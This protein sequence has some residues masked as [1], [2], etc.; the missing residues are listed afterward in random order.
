MV[1]CPDCNEELSQFSLSNKNRKNGLKID[2]L[3]EIYENSNEHPELRSACSLCEHFYPG[4]GDI[5]IGLY[6]LKTKSEF[7]IYVQTPLGQQ[8]I[9]SLNLKMDTKSIKQQKIREEVMTNLK[10]IRTKKA[11]E[12]VKATEKSIKG[13]D[14]FMNVLSPCINCHNCMTVC[15]ICYCKTCLFKSP[16]FDHEP[17]QYL[18]WARRK[19][20]YRLP[21]DTMLF[22]LTRLNHMVLS[23]VGCGMCTS[24]CPADLPVGRVFRTIAQQVQAAFDYTPGRSVDDPLPLITFRE[25]EWTEIGEE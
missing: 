3:Y 25:D 7:L 15:P 13:I 16:T 23:C 1:K 9:E 6:G 5:I 2:T 21:A 12:L 8:A 22:H 14:N 17:M 19:G 4:V 24:N 11:S 20:A 18:T 10:E